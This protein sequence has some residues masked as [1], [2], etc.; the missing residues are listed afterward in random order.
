[1]CTSV[2]PETGVSYLCIRYLFFFIYYLIQQPSVSHCTH[3]FHFFAF[4]DPPVLCL[5]F[6]FFFFCVCLTCSPFIFLQ[7]THDTSFWH[8]ELLLFPLATTCLYPF[9]SLPFFLLFY[10]FPFLRLFSAR[11]FCRMICIALLFY[12]AIKKRDF[13]WCAIMKTITKHFVLIYSCPETS[14]GKSPT[15][16][17]PSRSNGHNHLRIG[18]QQSCFAFGLASW[19]RPSYPASWK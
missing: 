9:F 8:F 13:L 11:L 14:D 2:L 18:Q 1:M 15:G 5:V 16:E 3:E 7:Q 17:T 19:K 12:C 6:V 10:L 4:A